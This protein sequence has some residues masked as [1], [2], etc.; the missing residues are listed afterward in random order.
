MVELIV[1]FGKL[2]HHDV[3]VSRKFDLYEIYKEATF[4]ETEIFKEFHH[5]TNGEI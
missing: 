2:H 4:I 3:C 5:A 1:S